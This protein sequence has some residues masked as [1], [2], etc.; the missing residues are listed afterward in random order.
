M[1]GGGGGSG[2]VVVQMICKYQE[3]KLH[4]QTKKV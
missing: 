1:S 4:T 2:N 3:Q